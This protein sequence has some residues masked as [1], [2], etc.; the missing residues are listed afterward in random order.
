VKHWR[1]LLL[2]PA[3]GWIALLI[4]N[5]FGA[6]SLVAAGLFLLTAYAIVFKQSPL[7][8]MGIPDDRL[9]AARKRLRTKGK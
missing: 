5:P 3:C 7:S 9:P 8:G 6:V 2:L 4:Y 1:W